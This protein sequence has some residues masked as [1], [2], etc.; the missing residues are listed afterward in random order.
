M[1]HLKKGKKLNRTRSHLKSMLKNM[2]VS[3]INF[4][5]IKTTLTKAKLLKTVVEPIISIAKKDN[6]YNRNIIF[7]ILKNR[8]IVAK[9]FNVLGPRL[10]NENGGY[11]KII[12]YNY[13]RSDGSIMSYILFKDFSLKFT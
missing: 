3:L 13:R 4:E 9:L 6:P 10:K 5:I 12:K 8:K 7:S 11:T 2:I 1:R